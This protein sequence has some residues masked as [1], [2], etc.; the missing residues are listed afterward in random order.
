MHSTTFW[1]TAI[2]V[3]MVAVLISGCSGSSDP[4]ASPGGA[5]GSG[6]T[7][8]VNFGY[9]PENW[10]PG[11]EMEGGPLRIVYE[12]LLAPGDGGQPGPFLA[13]DYELTP[14]DLTL[15]L[16]EG[17]TFHDGEPF[18]ADAVAA[19][20]ALVKDSATAYSGALGAIESVEVVDDLTIRFD[21]SRPTPSLPQTLTTRT[22]PIGSPAAIEDGS[23]AEHPVG[24]GP[25]AY[26]A[27]ASVIGTRLSFE[28]F[29]DYWG[30]VPAFANIELF[31]IVEEEARAAA[32][33]SGE[34]DVSDM[35][36][37]TAETLGEGFEHLAYPAI[38]NNVTFF[39]RGPG[40]IFEST[41]LRQAV[42]YAIDAQQMADL[43]G[44]G[45]VAATQHFVEG[46]YGYN[47][48]IEGLMTDLDRAK[49]L[50]AEA[51]SPTVNT[52][53]LAAP[54]NST[55]IEIYMTQASEIGDFS[56]TVTQV[57]PPQF[58]GEWNSGRYPLGLGA[59]DQLTPYEWYTTWFAAG[60]PANPSGAESDELAA[61]AEAAIAA[62]DSDE[63][64]GLWGEV[65]RIISEEALT[66]AHAQGMEIL[67]WNPD[68][69]T[70]V[71]A[72]AELWEPK[73]LPFR[74][75]APAQ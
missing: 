68:T 65:T 41:E 62:G 40:G 59:N 10:S 13:T 23:I 53:M 6:E 71:A 29:E 36:L 8:R 34:I 35:D 19:N 60:A 42:C 63:A 51:G 31:N 26:N 73:L 52:E 3:G 44:E 49:D 50:Y 5:G 27:D 21:L 25:W 22:L 12:T 46:E 32:L 1:K 54:Y 43:D 17:V 14:E 20:V 48:D 30:D 61:A 33:Q 9:L 58:N 75:L 7:L 39:D 67:A 18:D 2:P 37:K 16:R 38:R 24:T 28:G 69:V 64:E 4:D 15:H 74:D 72:P 47:P 45:G 56:V 55:Q 66:C 11:Q 57:P 70:G